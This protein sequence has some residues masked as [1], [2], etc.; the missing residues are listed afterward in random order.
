[1]SDEKTL[2]ER[3]ADL[4]KV[5]VASLPGRMSQIEDA[6]KQWAESDGGGTDDVALKALHNEAHKL[7]GSASTYGFHDL[8]N[9]ARELE[10][11]CQQQMGESGDGMGPPG[12][13]AI[14][15]LIG[16]VTKQLKAVTG[17]SETSPT[18]HD[19]GPTPNQH[20][21]GPVMLVTSDSGAAADVRSR[22][23]EA[24]YQVTVY[25][26]PESLLRTSESR[27]PVAIIVDGDFDG[28]NIAGATFLKGARASYGGV[29]DIVF[30]SPRDDQI[31]RDAALRAGCQ[32]FMVK[33]LDPK[34]IIDLL[35]DSAHPQHEV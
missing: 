17:G 21:S 8:G 14:M 9:V 32:H 10:V 5:Y 18:S 23:A 22:L 13:P 19:T 2:E 26:T 11:A 30:V 3:L 31:A 34:A 7:T 20:K 6:G 33:P 25:R 1:M 15:E 27:A 4:T 24:G 28:D 35:D 29:P 16:G 12:V